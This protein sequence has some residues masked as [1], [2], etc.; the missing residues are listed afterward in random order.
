M[1]GRGRNL[2]IFVTGRCPVEAPAAGA[3]DRAEAVKGKVKS[4]TGG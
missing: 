1:P 4:W 2:E 3:A